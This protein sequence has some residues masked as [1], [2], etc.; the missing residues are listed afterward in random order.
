MASSLFDLSGKKALVTGGT[1]GIGRACATALAM[2][3]ADVAIVG[4]NESVGAKVVASLRELGGDAAFIRCDISDEAQT[5][6]MVD[7]VVRRFGRLDIAVNNAGIFRPGPDEWQPVHEWEEMIATNLTGTWLCARAEMQQMIKQTP[8]EGKIIN[9]TSIAASLAVANGAYDA[10]KAA[11]V[12]L[13]RTLAARWGRYNINVNCVSPGHLVAAL[14][15]SRSLE[16]RRQVRDFTPLGYVQREEDLYGPILF[17]ASGASDYITGQ[18]MVVDGGYTLSRWT[19]RLE[20]SVPPRVDARGEVAH[21]K[22][23]LDFQG[24]P[25]DDDG[26]VPPSRS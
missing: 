24:I 6:S 21:M 5:Q 16:E 7:A 1:R 22:T 10:S 8:I 14:G 15:M 11:V 20:R 26:I 9:I 13:T 3:G 25:H 12:Q 23:D 2:G 18:E 19:R 17:L 4:R